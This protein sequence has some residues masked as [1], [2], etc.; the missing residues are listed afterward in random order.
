MLC[1]LAGAFADR[2]FQA[3]AGRVDQ[4]LGQEDAGQKAQQAPSE[5]STPRARKTVT[6]KRGTREDEPSTFRHLPEQTA[7]AKCSRYPSPD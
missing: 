7:K 5:T 6:R 3:A 4:Y 2:L 1:L